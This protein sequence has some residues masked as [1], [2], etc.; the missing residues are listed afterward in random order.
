[1]RNQH[2]FGDT[3]PLM[4]KRHGGICGNP[5]VA[6]GGISFPSRGDSHLSLGSLN[7]KGGFCVCLCFLLVFF[8]YVSSLLTTLLF[9]ADKPHTALGLSCSCVFLKTDFSSS[10]HQNVLNHMTM[11]SLPNWGFDFSWDLASQENKG[12]ISVSRKRKWFSLVAACGWYSFNDVRLPRF[13]R[14]GE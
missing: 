12:H 8:F 11:C 13:H 4:S 9:S 14:E 1:M 6:D 2:G 5:A 7:L 10:N 3:R